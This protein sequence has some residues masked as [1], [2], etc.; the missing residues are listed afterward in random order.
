VD[1]RQKDETATPEKKT[2]NPLLVILALC[3]AL[4]Y[5]GKLSGLFRLD[6][7]AENVLDLVLIGG[8]VLV[9]V[10]SQLL[11]SSS[12]SSDHATEIPEDSNNEHR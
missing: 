7:D 10:I 6:R 1:T 9:F 4:Y 2:G 12:H 8:L 3:G 11:R 5:G